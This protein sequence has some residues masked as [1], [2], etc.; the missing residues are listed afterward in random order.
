[1]TIKFLDLIHVAERKHSVRAQQRS[2]ESPVNI[3][4]PI[5]PRRSPQRS[6]GTVDGPPSAYP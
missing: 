3:T 6:L 5:F 2:G 4:L 1:M